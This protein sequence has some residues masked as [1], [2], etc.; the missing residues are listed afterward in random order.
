MNKYAI[1]IR[2]LP[3]HCLD[4]VDAADR[5]LARTLVLRDGQAVAA[6][7]PARD[8]ERIDPPDP[9]S[10]GADPLVALAGTCRHD[11]FV[12]S[13]LADLGATSLWSR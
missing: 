1:P 11:A 9:G 2:E 12:D 13:L 4:A 5:T 3:Q 8:L 7:V 10:S 6:I